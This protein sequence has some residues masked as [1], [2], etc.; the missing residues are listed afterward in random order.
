MSD[1]IAQRM[2]VASSLAVQAGELALRYFRADELPIE[3]KGPQDLVSEA[4]RA[5]EQLIRD[6][7]GKYFSGDGFLGEEGGGTV[8]AEWTWVVD[9]IDG[10]Q[11]FLAGIPTW[12]VSIG[13]V[14]R[15]RIVGGVIHDPNTA[16]TFSCG[17]RAGAFCNGRPMRP[18]A[19]TNFT[20]GMVEVGWSPRVTT[21][22]TARLIER[23]L[24]RGGI[25]HRGG[26]GAL[27][28]AYVADGRYLA[29]FEA[30]MNVWDS[31]AGAALV[32]AAGGWVNDILNGDGMNRGSLV[33]ASAPGLVPAFLELVRDAG[34]ELRGAQS[35]RG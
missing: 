16:E 13:L 35:R 32:A 11:C 6:A 14:H 25:Y 17:G 20:F 31:C 24:E 7:L 28:M 15:G 18:A 27:G 9:P 26:S 22:S 1:A 2:D 12:C 5:V 19:G 33:A 21:E 29:Y 30:H 3:R 10:T 23:L 34:F 8:D 4:D